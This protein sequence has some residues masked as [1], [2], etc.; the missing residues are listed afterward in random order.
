[1]LNTRCCTSEKRPIFLCREPFRRAEGRIGWGWFRF[2]SP[3]SSC[4]SILMS[5]NSYLP[6]HGAC[7][8]RGTAPSDRPGRRACSSGNDHFVQIPVEPWRGFVNADEAVV[9]PHRLRVRMILSHVGWRR[10]TPWQPSAAAS[11]SAGCPSLVVDRHFG[12]L[13]THSGF[14]Q[15]PILQVARRG[16]RRIRKLTATAG[17]R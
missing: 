1:M 9:D 12:R 10:V 14:W 2:A 15:V 7:T 3:L 17:R 11:G 4:V 13:H 5:S 8:R 16:M 6:G